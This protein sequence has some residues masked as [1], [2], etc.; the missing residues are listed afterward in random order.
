MKGGVPNSDLA[1]GE[2]EFT[3]SF[4]IGGESWL[5]VKFKTEILSYF[6]LISLAVNTFPLASMRTK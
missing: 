2:S 4:I 3:T 6:S 5:S 1:R